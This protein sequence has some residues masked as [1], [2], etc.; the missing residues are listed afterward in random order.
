M[1]QPVRPLLYALHGLLHL[2][3]FDD[4]TPRGYSQ[5]HGK[6]DQLLT[7]LW[8][9]SVFRLRPKTRKPPSRRLKRKALTRA[10]THT[11]TGASS[12]RSA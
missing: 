12:C 2:C 7:E 1:E 11:T 6:E 9:G 5:M 3:G 4:T 8:I 10:I